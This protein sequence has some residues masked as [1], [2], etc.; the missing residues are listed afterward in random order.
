MERSTELRFG[1]IKTRKIVNNHLMKKLAIFI[2]CAILIVAAKVIPD[3]NIFEMDEIRNVTFVIDAVAAAE[4]ELSF[5]QSGTDAIVEINCDAAQEK[6][7]KYHPK[8]VILEFDAHKKDYVAEF[9][10]MQQAQTQNI[11][12]MTIVYGYTSKFD[13][14][15]Y[16]DGKKVNVMI[17]EKQGAL[18]VGFPII[19][20]GF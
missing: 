9:L 20:T 8:S 17:V 12:D 14:C 18:L 6:Y 1:D 3:K 10:A 15:Q 2:I 5:V 19:M 7:E 13:K 11:Q 4:D 16:V